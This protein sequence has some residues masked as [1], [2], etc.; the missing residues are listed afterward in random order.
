ML[1]FS[2]LDSTQMELKRRRMAGEDRLI[3]VR[4]DYQR[5]GHGRRGTSWY[6]PRGQSL[7]VSYVASVE[8]P[9]DRAAANLALTGAAAVARVIEGLTQL[10]TRLRWPND[11]LLGEQ[12]VAGIIVELFGVRNGTANTMLA[13]IGIGVNVN[14]TQ[15]PENLQAS[16]TSLK[17][18]TSRDWSIEQADAMLR[19][20]LFAMLSQVRAGSLDGVLRF[21]RERDGTTSR[22]YVFPRDGGLL[23]AT[24]LEITERGT[25][26]VR[27]PDGREEELVN[28]THA[29][30]VAPKR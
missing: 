7:L 8:P 29:A 26:L 17:L 3:G 16:A 13:A 18:R 25:L 10:E 6:A 27:L 22:R 20:A 11:V 12:K 9:F 5:H 23:T 15:F 28:A 14:V 2:E 21:W 4:A 19:T 1:E 30:D 24:A